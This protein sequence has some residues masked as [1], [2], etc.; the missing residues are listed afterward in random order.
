MTNLWGCGAQEFHPSPDERSGSPCTRPG[1]CRDSTMNA[2]IK[3]G[4]IQ[5]LLDARMILLS[6]EQ[7]TIVERFTPS[8]PFVG[9]MLCSG[10]AQNS[11]VCWFCCDPGE[12]RAIVR[13]ARRAGSQV[14]AR[15]IR[16]T[17]AKERRLS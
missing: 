7:G 13:I 16:R 15:Q 12:C 8:Q 5:G 4:A 1:R 6:G 3:P 9:D 17:E 10:T 2:S 14:C 11:S